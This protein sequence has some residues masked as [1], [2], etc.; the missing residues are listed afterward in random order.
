MQIEC[1][2]GYRLS[3]E[4]EQR[5]RCLSTGR[6]QR[7]KT[8]IPAFCSPYKPPLHGHLPLTLPPSAPPSLSICP[9]HKPALPLS[10]GHPLTRHRPSLSA[11]SSSAL[12]L[13]RPS[14]HSSSVLP[15]SIG[16]PSPSALSTLF[17]CTSLWNTLHSP[18]SR[19][20]CTQLLIPLHAQGLVTQSFHLY[21]PPNKPGQVGTT[22]I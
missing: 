19:F 14:A 1:D 2:K 11:H 12:P 5:P 16:P 13:H 21:S 9:L 15:L 7:G 17:I 10:V 22:V 4:G 20:T 18:P 3:E 6:F 8:C